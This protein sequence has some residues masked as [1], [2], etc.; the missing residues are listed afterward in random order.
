MLP[1]DA[2]LRL[3]NT[4]E[5]SAR[6]IQVSI[7]WGPGFSPTQQPAS[8]SQYDQIRLSNYADRTLTGL[9]VLLGLLND[10]LVG[11]VIVSLHDG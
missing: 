11:N 9:I 4:T 3:N 10:A 5:T 6:S 7:S 1:N 2:I 8:P